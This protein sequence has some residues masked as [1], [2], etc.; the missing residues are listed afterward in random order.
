MSLF[1]IFLLGIVI[2]RPDLAERAIR[3]A[4]VLSQQLGHWNFLIILVTSFVESFP[5][6]GILVP[7]Q[8]IM[9]VVGWFYGQSSFLLA[10]LWACIG[11]ILWNWV[12]Y[13]L[14][15]KYGLRFLDTYGDVFALGKTEQKILSK[16]IRE[17]GA[18]FIIFGK[19]HNFTRA[20]V[21]FLA[22]SFSMK[23]NS[24]WLYNII[25]SIFWSFSILVLGVFFTTYID[26]VLNWISWFFLAVFIGIIGYIAL[27]KRKEFMEY[28]H[29]KQK[30]LQE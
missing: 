18:V 11:A 8:Q 16:R 14:G 17:N 26:I 21:P 5:V 6:I 1:F 30:E 25:G 12:G 13:W 15:V 28:L 22:G 19:F 29:D 9:L 20:F 24:F 2:F 23:N 7:G 4:G 3:A 10:V 27:Y